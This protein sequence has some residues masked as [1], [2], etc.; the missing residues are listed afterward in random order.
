MA[1]LIP[2]SLPLSF[3]LVNYLKTFFCVGLWYVQRLNSNLSSII[4][5]GSVYELAVSIFADR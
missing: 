3:N 1:D 5:P 4:L 2:P